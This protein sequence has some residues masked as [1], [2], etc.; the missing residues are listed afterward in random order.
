MPA[1]VGIDFGTSNTHVA[2]CNDAGQGPLFAVPIKIAGRASNMTCVLWRQTPDGGEKVEAFGSVAA[3]AWSQFD[4]EERLDR[5]LALGFKP[6]IASSPDA[7]ADATSFLGKI[8]EAVSVVQ[9]AAVQG[10][11]TI[12]GAPAEVPR[13]QKEI[14]RQ[15]ARAAGFANAE[16]VEEPLGALA[17]HLTNGSLTLAQAR[18]GVVVVDFGGGTLD[19]ALV[20]AERGLRTPWGDPALG[21]R[22]FDDVFYRWVEDRCGAFNVSE[23]E[24]MGLWQKECREMKEA[25]S[26]RWTMAGDGMADFTYRIDCGSRVQTLKKASVAEFLER[27]RSYSPS[28]VALA[29]FQRFGLPG[30][31]Q[32]GRS[33]DLLDWIRRTMDRGAIHS[34]ERFGKVILTGGSSDWPFMTRLAAEVFNIDPE[35]DIIRSEDPETTIGSGLALYFALR[36]RHQK[37]RTA[38]DAARPVARDAIASAV[39]ALIEEVSARLAKAIIANVMPRIEE[40]FQTWYRKGGSLRRVGEEVEAA[41]AACEPENLRLADSER[42]VLVSGLVRLFSEHLTEFMQAHEISKDIVRYVPAAAA[43]AAPSASHGDTENLIAAEIG[44]M[45]GTMTAVAA[46][47]GA[48]IA[49]ALHVKLVILL[50]I[51]HPMLAAAA[52]VGALGAYLGIGQ[53]VGSAV[54]DAVK[55]HEFN[56]FTLNILRLALSEAALAKRLADGRRAAEADLQRAIVES[57]SADRDAAP[58][59]VTRAADAFDV[60]LR[61]VIADLGVLERAASA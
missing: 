36:E 46:G 15:I 54:Q 24:A 37:R 1:Y 38:L 18:E 8:R 28:A 25:F 55:D 27:A 42:D 3:E 7:R 53:T 6:D 35:T 49:G 10:G 59:L 60:M 34:G 19:L 12:I 9:S 52:S 47:V 26:R 45:A 29:Y 14:T 30:P 61:K 39:R 40:L 16:C 58:G 21:G 22:L 51:T 56:P 41:C 57:L 48:A 50:A 43:L 32:E 5:R 20:D 4:S 2:V 17:Y 23:R 31:L 13:E 11:L 33:V 44:E